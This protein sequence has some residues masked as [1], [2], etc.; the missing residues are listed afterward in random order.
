MREGT[1]NSLVVFGLTAMLWAFIG[2]LMLCQA[3]GSDHMLQDGKYSVEL[4]VATTTDPL[5]TVGEVQ[6]VDWSIDHKE[7][8][9]YKLTMNESTVLRGADLEESVIFS[10]IKT[11]GSETCPFYIDLSLK[12]VPNESG[13]TGTASQAYTFCGSYDANTNVTQWVDWNTTYNLIGEHL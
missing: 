13:F 10:L 3:C 8:S 6:F 1:K 4:S 9:Q 2:I 11:I 12:L 5:T 7:D